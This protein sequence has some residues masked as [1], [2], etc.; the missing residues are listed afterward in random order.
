VGRICTVFVSGVTWSSST[1]DRMGYNSDTYKTIHIAVNSLSF[2][3][4]TRY[5]VFV[6]IRV[7]PSVCL[8][9]R[10]RFFGRPE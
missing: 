3:T 9:K 5:F 6:G 8:S 4:P 10:V 1:K 7:D 2:K